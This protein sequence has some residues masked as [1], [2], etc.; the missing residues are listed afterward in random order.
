MLRMVSTFINRCWIDQTIPRR[1]KDVMIHML[2]K[3]GDTSICDNFRPIALN[4]T[5]L[6]I[7]DK[8]LLNRL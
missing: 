1:L 6:R 3:K 4:N 7:Y 8:V 2:Y 5:L